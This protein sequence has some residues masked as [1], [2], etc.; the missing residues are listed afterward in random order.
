MRLST[1]AHVCSRLLAF[2]TLRFR[3]CVCQ[4]LSAFVCVCLRPPLSCAPLRDTEFRF[5]SDSASRKFRAIPSVYSM[6]LQFGPRHPKVFV[7]K[8]W[9]GLRG[10]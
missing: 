4:R 5:A 9:G 2:S 7:D 10:V 6:L 8:I 1:F 3:L